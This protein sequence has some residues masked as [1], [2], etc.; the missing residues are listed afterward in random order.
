MPVGRMSRGSDLT[1]LPALPYVT[2]DS[3]VSVSGI[4]AS[5]LSLA[6]GLL[7]IAAPEHVH[8]REDH[9]HAEFV[10]HRHMPPHGLFDHHREH[11]ASV[12]DHDAP[13]LT[14]TTVFTV[15]ASVILAAPERLMSALVEPPAP[16]RIERSQTKGDVPI[17]GPP[18]APS[19]LR[20]PPFSPAS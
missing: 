5:V 8:E 17:H 3:P 4:I 7:P 10:V 20:G 16:E 6:V 9:G 11:Q 1:C 13:I 2:Y 19:V 12:E 18:R 15:P 14:L